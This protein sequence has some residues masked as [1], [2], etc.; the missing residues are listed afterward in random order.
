MLNAF[1]EIVAQHRKLPGRYKRAIVAAHYA[2]LPVLASR[3]P[4]AQ[5]IQSPAT[6]ILLILALPAPQVEVRPLSIYD[7]LSEVDHD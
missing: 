2:G 1:G 5:A 6:D 7:Q 4:Q 3:T